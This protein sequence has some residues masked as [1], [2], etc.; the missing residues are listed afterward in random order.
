MQYL[1][2]SCSDM[3][4]FRSKAGAM[5]F[6]ILICSSYGEGGMRKVDYDEAQKLYD[7][8]CDNVELPNVEK[9]YQ[10]SLCSLMDYVSSLSKKETVSE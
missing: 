6:A 1:G 7:F 4:A 8:I 9:D 2:S 3:T 10:D 5:S